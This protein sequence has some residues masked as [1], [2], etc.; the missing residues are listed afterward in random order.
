MNYF[1]FVLYD[2]CNAENCYNVDLERGNFEQ[3]LSKAAKENWGSF[4]KRTKVYRVSNMFY[5]VDL[6]DFTSKQ[7]KK[8]TKDVVVGKDVILFKSHKEKLPFHSFPCTKSVNS[9]FY[10]NKLILK[11]HNRVFVNFEHQHH[12]AK[13]TQKIYINYNFEQSVDGNAI[14]KVFKR[15]EHV[16]GVRLPCVTM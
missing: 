9:T 4:V 14:D 3:M 11:V 2:G 13:L 15:I 12:E 7:Y 8:T 16:L 6:K 5:E 10:S 1:E